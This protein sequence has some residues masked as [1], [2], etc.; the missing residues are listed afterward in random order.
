MELSGPGLKMG[1]N[2]GEVLSCLGRLESTVGFCDKDFAGFVSLAGEE[3]CS[4]MGLLRKA[5]S[6]FFFLLVPLWLG[7]SQK[8]GRGL[9]QQ[10]KT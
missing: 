8:M 3:N 10:S 5:S 1:H 7:Q 4:R 2:T 9:H 6:H